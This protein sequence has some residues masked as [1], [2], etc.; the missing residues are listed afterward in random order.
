MERHETEQLDTNIKDMHLERP[1][2]SLGVVGL[3]SYLIILMGV[4]DVDDELYYHIY[5]IKL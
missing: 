3:L 2:F 5:L 1:R 4:C